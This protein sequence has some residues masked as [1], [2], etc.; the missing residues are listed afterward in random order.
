MRTFILICS[1]FAS[2]LLFASCE[3]VTQTE[4]KTQEVKKDTAHYGKEN[5]HFEKLSPQA[6]DIIKDWPVF[7]DFKGVSINL[8]NSTF[9]ELARK[10]GLLLTIT[11]SL[12]KSIP[13]TINS[14]AIQSR[15]V[16]VKTR[17]E[18]LNQEVKL[19]K[20]HPEKVEL[21]ISEAYKAINHFVVQIN[22]KLQ[23]DGI[24]IQR[25]ADEAAELKKQQRA[26]DSIFNLELQDQ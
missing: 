2:I 20:P 18:L 23:K 17:M 16:V 21:Y 12:S 6:D 9:E 19:G 24:D 13:D 8:Y 22:E 7:K 15:L 3:D 5:F 14:K 25:S 26:R 4:A 1:F 11:D 10:S